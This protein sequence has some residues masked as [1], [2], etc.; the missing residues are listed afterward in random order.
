MHYFSF[1][2]FPSKHVS[3]YSN[4][5]L[6]TDINPAPPANQ[7]IIL[8]DMYMLFTRRIQLNMSFAKPKT[9]FLVAI[10]PSP[11]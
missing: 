10:V 9:V 4:V 1:I 2:S 11:P 3:P 7:R 6:P 8:Y 5:S